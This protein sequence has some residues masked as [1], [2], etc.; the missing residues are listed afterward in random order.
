M[1]HA[2]EGL[3]DYACIL[4]VEGGGPFWVSVQLP[5]GRLSRG[6]YGDRDQALAAASALDKVAQRRWNRDRGGTALD[7][8]VPPDQV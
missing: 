2:G 6:P 8:R 5:A 4:E 7:L 1:D 3:P